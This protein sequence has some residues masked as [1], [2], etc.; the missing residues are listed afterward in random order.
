MEAADLDRRL[1]LMERRGVELER[2]LRDCRDG[3]T[4]AAAP[5]TGS[6]R[7]D[8]RTSRV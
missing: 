4:D 6:G 2:N 3:G 1:E 5:S 7:T 8:G